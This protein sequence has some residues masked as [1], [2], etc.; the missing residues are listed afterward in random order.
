[1]DWAFWANVGT[2]ASAALTAIA[3]LWTVW[4]AWD[5]S[6]TQRQVLSLQTAEKFSTD[7]KEYSKIM[8][9]L[10]A[11]YAAYKPISLKSFQA[12]IGADE[13]NRSHIDQ[14]LNY[15]ESLARGVTLGIYDENVI[16]IARRRPIIY[17][18]RGFE[19]YILET[20]RVEN[21]PRVW[22]QLETL[23]KKWEDVA[24]PS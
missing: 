3:L 8:S 19:A 16:M 17:A 21:N 18:F 23:A 13:E 24:P 15:Y 6:R 10:F 4:L 14:Y 12:A 20:R 5:N 9:K 1:M 22:R 2:V 11:E 7:I